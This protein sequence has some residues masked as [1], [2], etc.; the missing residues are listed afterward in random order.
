MM[1]WLLSLEWSGSTWPCL[2]WYRSQVPPVEPNAELLQ[3]A[4]DQTQGAGVFDAADWKVIVRARL[5]ELDL[6]RVARDV[7]PFLE[8]PEDV[9][10]LSRENLEALL[11][12]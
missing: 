8:R 4:L 11:R 10:L 2:C 1:Q 9:A 6:E 3:N 12:R 7:A 5:A